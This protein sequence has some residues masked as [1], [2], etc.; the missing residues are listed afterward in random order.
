[1]MSTSLQGST[2]H[3]ASGA[4][5]AQHSVAATAPG[6][7]PM[8]GLIDWSVLVLP[9]VIW[10]ASFLFIAEGLRAMAPNG[11]T[12][13]RIAIGFVTLS[14]IPASAGRSRDRICC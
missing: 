1:M 7:A 6:R 12:F 5:S 13:G 2:A 3:G 14:L 10:G 9:G 8:D 11:I 4:A